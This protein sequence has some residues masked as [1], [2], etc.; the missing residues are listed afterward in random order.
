MRALPVWLCYW[1]SGGFFI[2]WF[3]FYAKHGERGSK[4]LILGFVLLVI[5]AVLDFRRDS[6]TD[7][8]GLTSGP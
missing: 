1:A 8:G 4:P 3:Y 7:D 6:T 5:G 2:E